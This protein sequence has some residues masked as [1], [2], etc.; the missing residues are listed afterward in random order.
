[1][2]YTT[3]YLKLAPPL[4]TSLSP[5]TIVFFASIFFEVTNLFIILCSLK[6][7]R[8]EQDLLNFMKL[9][10]GIQ[11]W[12]IIIGGIGWTQLVRCSHRLIVNLAFLGQIL[13]FSLIVWRHL[14]MS[15]SLFL[16]ALCK[17]ILLHNYGR[18]NLRY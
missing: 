5:P 10:R 3:N 1:M 13:A 14:W 7:N 11:K 2:S 8:M 12:Q 15:L 4:S 16:F 9:G 18:G 17:M 6:K